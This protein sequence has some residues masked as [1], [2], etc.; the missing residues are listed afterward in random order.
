LRS[1]LASAAIAAAALLAGCDSDK[2]PN[3]S[4]RHMQPLSEATL[5]ELDAKKMAKESPI[6]I[7]IFKEESELEVWKVDKSGRFAPLRTYPSVAGQANWV[8]RS[9]KAIGKRPR[10]STPSRPT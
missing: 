2:I 3:I 8:Q 10:A 1:L 6:L 5:A 7:R 9:K 4:G